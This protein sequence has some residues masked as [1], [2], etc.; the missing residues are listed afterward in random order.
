MDMPKGALNTY[1]QALPVICL[2]TKKECTGCWLQRVLFQSGLKFVKHYELDAAVHT[3]F[4]KKRHWY[5]FKGRHCT[6]CPWGEAYWDWLGCR[7]RKSR[8]QP[9][10]AV[11]RELPGNTAQ[12]CWCFR[13]FSSTGPGWSFAAAELHYSTDQ[14]SSADKLS[15]LLAGDF[16][17]LNGHPLRLHNALS[18]NGP[19]CD[20]DTGDHITS[21]CVWGSFWAQYAMTGL[22]VWHNAHLSSSLPLSSTQRLAAYIC[23]FDGTPTRITMAIVFLFSTIW[24]QRCNQ[25]CWKLCSGIYVHT[26]VHWYTH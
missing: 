18:A 21:G 9:Q 24:T 10:I 13:K 1:G 20:V 6:D 19:A 12:T 4:S 14:Y 22:G 5:L 26:D 11:Q 25:M 23:I 16:V 2:Y 15:A 8:P 17:K 7:M 3:T